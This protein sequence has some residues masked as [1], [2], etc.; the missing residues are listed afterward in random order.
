MDISK[1]KEQ[2][3][4]LEQLRKDQ[5]EQKEQLENEMAENLA[6]LFNELAQEFIPI[7]NKLIEC[8]ELFVEE[9][10]GLF[11]K[12]ATKGRNKFLKPE[13]K[14][15]IEKTSISENCRTVQEKLKTFGKY[16]EVFRNLACPGEKVESELERRKEN[17]HL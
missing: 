2:K 6:Q 9:K 1:I 14:Q 5:G 3:E 11:I 16:D 4:R 13:F 15:L 10:P 8:L 17:L 7:S 12:Y